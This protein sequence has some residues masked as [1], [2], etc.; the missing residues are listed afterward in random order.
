VPGRRVTK[1]TK[2]AI[3]EYWLGTAVGSQRFPNN[4]ALFDPDFP[5]CFA[6]GSPALEDG[7]HPPSWKVWNQATLDR[8]H[9]CPHSLGG[10][11]DPTNLVLL[12][13]SCHR[14]APN[15]GDPCYMIKWMTER[16]TCID[17][18]S[19]LLE[20]TLDTFELREDFS[21]VAEADGRAKMFSEVYG[22][23][24]RTWIGTHGWYI[25]ESTE[26]AVL[27]EAIKRLARDS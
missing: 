16:D 6:C 10:T 3:A 2:A 27:A 22:G 15:V 11:D 26:E 19:H 7:D 14:D 8:C 9:I 23:L 18:F 20:R 21:R 24:R 1:T 5:A 25:N 4:E 12:C 13:S 17:R